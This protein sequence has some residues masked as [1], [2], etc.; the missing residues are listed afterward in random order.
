[1]VWVATPKSWEKVRICEKWRE[2]YTEQA[3]QANEEREES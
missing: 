3:E 1:M 2:N